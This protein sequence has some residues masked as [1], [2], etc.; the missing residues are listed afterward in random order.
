MNDETKVFEELL[1]NEPL[2]LEGKHFVTHWQPLPT[3][4]AAPSGRKG[5]NQT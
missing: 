4:P 3:P 1:A 5:D 2:R